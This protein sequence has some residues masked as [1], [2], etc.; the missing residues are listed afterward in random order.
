MISLV[1]SCRLSCK[2]FVTIRFVT[3]CIFLLLCTALIRHRSENMRFRLT[4]FIVLIFVLF[5]S[6]WHKKYVIQQ[7]RSWSLWLCKNYV[8]NPVINAQWHAKVGLPFFYTPCI[9]PG[10]TKMR[11]DESWEAR[12]CIRVLSTLVRRSNKVRVVEL[13]DHSGCYPVTQTKL[14]N[15]LIVNF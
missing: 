14:V 15:F 8:H 10:Q 12:V 7:V 5:C 11:M 6:K 2:P 4:I 9:R 13:I 3:N 1:K